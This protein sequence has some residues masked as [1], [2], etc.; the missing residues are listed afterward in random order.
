MKIKKGTPP[1]KN[2]QKSIGKASATATVFVV[3]MVI[4]ATKRKTG[5]VCDAGFIE[6]ATII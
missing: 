3:T 6:Q 4:T 5:A 2:P 1:P